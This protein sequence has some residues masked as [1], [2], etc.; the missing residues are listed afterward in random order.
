MEGKERAMRWPAVE[1]VSKSVIIV[2]CSEASHPTPNEVT[3]IYTH[4][5]D[6]S[7]MDRGCIHGSTAANQQVLSM[8]NS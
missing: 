1:V 6:I 2:F 5:N 7:Y 3:I 8:L 4:L